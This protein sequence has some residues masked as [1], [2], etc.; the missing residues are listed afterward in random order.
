MGETEDAALTV[1]EKPAAP[2]VEAAAPGDVTVPLPDVDPGAVADALVVAGTS[3]VVADDGAA[4]E[5]AASGRSNVTPD[6]PQ[7][8]S[9]NSE[10]T[11]KGR[12]C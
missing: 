1:G 2:E 12:Q 11:F 6:A 9:A 3:L 8:A 7:S 4:V 5:N 10:V